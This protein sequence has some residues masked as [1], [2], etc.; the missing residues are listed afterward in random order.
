LIDRGAGQ[1]VVVVTKKPNWKNN[2]HPLAGCLSV[3]LGIAVVGGGVNLLG[4][5]SLGEPGAVIAVALIGG[6]ALLWWALVKVLGGGRKAR[7]KLEKIAYPPCAACGQPNRENHGCHLEAIGRPLG[8]RKKRDGSYGRTWNGLVRDHYGVL[9]SCSHEHKHPKEAQLCAWTVLRGYQSGKLG[10]VV[11]GPRP[12]AETIA[13]RVPLADLNWRQML[14]DVDGRCHYCGDQFPDSALQKEH[15]TPLSRGGTNHASN[16]VV[17]CGPCNREK[18][19]L[20]EEEY[21]QLRE[22]V[23]DRVKR[24]DLGRKRSSSSSN[25]KRV[26][27]DAR[28]RYPGECPCGGKFV[29]RSGPFGRFYGCSRYP[30]CRETRSLAKNRK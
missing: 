19:T 27:T 22:K 13:H 10:D 30:A 18:G 14:R 1:V 9:S 15:K 25:A 12:G 11:V 23:A 28:P 20:T 29:M 5:A 26:S 6:V 3:I 7:A 8:Y 24:A 4:R 17:S 16:I 21:I 2:E